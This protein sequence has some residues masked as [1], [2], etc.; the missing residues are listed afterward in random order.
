M[1][2]VVLGALGRMGSALCARFKNKSDILLLAGVDNAY[3]S[4]EHS[5]KQRDVT[6]TMIY[7]TLAEVGEDFDV[8]VNFAHHSLAFEVAKYAKDRHIALCEFC[9]GHT[10]N[11]SECI[12]KLSEYVPVFFASNTALGIAHIAEISKRLAC[13]FPNAQIEIVETHHAKKADAPSGT[14]LM[15]ANEIAKVR[16]GDIV[17]ERQGERKSDNEIGIHSIRLGDV[18]G[19]HSVYID[20]KDERI[21]LKHIALSRELYCEGAERAIR[22]ICTKEK[23]VY[24]MQD[25]LD[26]YKD[27]ICT[28]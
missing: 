22:F 6:Q 24:R 4:K 18:F 10:A 27:G 3:V 19:E 12:E 2:V 23:G 13:V 28:T 16:G 20:T 25:L 21:I 17:F 1:K 15:L 26:E 14:A 8:L 7:R 5:D 11:E 9:T